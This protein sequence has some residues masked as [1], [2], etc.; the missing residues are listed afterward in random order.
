MVENEKRRQYI[1]TVLHGHT[2]CQTAQVK[3][4]AKFCKEPP[5]PCSINRHEMTPTNTT[6]KKGEVITAVLSKF[7]DQQNRQT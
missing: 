4:K 7:N 3:A 6:E 1:T 5:S 2:H